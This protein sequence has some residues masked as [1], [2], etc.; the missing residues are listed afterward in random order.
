MLKNFVFVS[1]KYSSKE[2]EYI[3]LESPKEEEKFVE[4]EN[5]K[6]IL[7]NLKKDRDEENKKKIIYN[8]IPE[9]FSFEKE[10]K[11]YKKYFD[12]FFFSKP[13]NSKI[14]SLEI[15]LYKDVFEVRWRLK[16]KK[17]HI[18][19]VYKQTKKEALA[20]WIHEFWHFLDLYI[21][22][23]NVFKDLSYDFYDISW[24]ERNILKAGAKRQDFVSGYSMTNMYEDFAESFTFYILHNKE[25]EK[26]AKKS[27]KLQKKY[28]FFKKNIFITDE[29]I[30]DEYS[31]K[32]EKKDIWDTTKLDFNFINFEKYLKSFDEK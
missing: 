10:I 25:F 21:L 29:F 22:K 1:E 26:R 15:N 14:S 28:D 16:D 18:F 7:A 19:W 11:D 9:K 17:I 2:E 20:V 31:F 24:D 5:L 32:I 30:T 12:V 27:L 4:S 23:K 8:Y 13:I 6:N 3:T